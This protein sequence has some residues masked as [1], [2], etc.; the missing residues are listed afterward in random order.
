MLYRQAFDTFIRVFGDVGY[1]VNKKNFV[2]RV[3]DSFGAVFLSCLTREPRGFDAI[4]ADISSHF[5]EIDETLLKHDAKRFYAMLERDGFIVSGRTEEE[6]N[7]KDKRFSYSAIL[8]KTIKNDFTPFVSRAEKKTQMVLEEHF[9]NE[10][11]LM[12]LQI[13]LTSRC[14][15]RCVHCYIPHQKKD[16][17]IDDDLFYYTLKQCREMGV[18]NITL[19]GGE[20]LMHPRFIE[21][22][23]KAKEYDFSVN[24]LSNLTLLNDEI[25]NAMKDIRLSSVQVS[26][27]SM[28]PEIHDSITTVPGSFKKTLLSIETLVK[29]DIPLQISCPILKQNKNNYADVLRYARK[30]KVRAVTD[31]IIMARFDQTMDNLENRLDINDI[32]DVISNIIEND[33]SYQMKIRTTNFNLVDKIDRSNDIVCGVC[34]SSLGMVANGNIYPCAGWQSYIL[35]NIREQSLEDIWNDSPKVK[36]LRSLRKKDFHQCV[37]CP[38]KAFC[39]MCMVRNANE[40]SEGDPFKINKHFCEVARINRKIVLEY[41]K[42]K[43]PKIFWKL[44]GINKNDGVYD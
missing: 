34:I 19:S 37:E 5:S 44:S 36:Y 38:D 33:I 41:R 16:T 9:K 3:T 18:M 17:D 2:D 11:H 21:F 32:K 23:L 14:N 24:I 42:R 1:I 7:R 39:S 8:P 25:V 29:N 40:N 22:L 28:I 43:T 27:Y 30:I 12:A 15:E 4:V 35:G 10:P 13:E 26:L 20:P 6:L 31:H